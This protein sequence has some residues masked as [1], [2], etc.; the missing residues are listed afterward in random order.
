MP[1]SLVQVTEGSGKKLHTFQRTI[2]AN[3]VEDEIMVLGEQYLA[4][5]TIGTQV[6]VSV[7]TASS[8]LLQI[9]AGAS[10]NVYLRSIRVY[11]AVAATTAAIN[12]LAVYRLTTAGTGGT[13]I[14]AVAHDTTDTAAGAT[15]MTLPTV[16][17]TEAANWVDGAEV[18]WLQTMPTAVDFT[19]LRAAWTWGGN[20]GKA[21]RIPAGTANG[22]AVKNLNAVAAATVI[23][24]AELSE[25]NF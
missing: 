9:M 24:I 7:A 2:G 14:T 22:I 18:Y 16:K 8:H 21:L 19:A 4:S 11:Q 6:Q 20:K 23:I 5:Y 17:G 13:A 1:E 12:F 15:G 25:A 10:L 3:N